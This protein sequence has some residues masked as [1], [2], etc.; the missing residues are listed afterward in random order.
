MLPGID[1]DIREVL[2]RHRRITTR[3]MIAAVVTFS[4]ALG[5]LIHSIYQL[6]Q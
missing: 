6:C 4:G 3:L 2:A 1:K 5:L